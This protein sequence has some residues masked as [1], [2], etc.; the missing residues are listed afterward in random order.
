L[1]AGLGSFD[2]PKYRAGG[3]CLLHIEDDSDV[4]KVIAEVAHKKLSMEMATALEE[5]RKELYAD[6]YDLALLDLT[7]RMGKVM[8]CYRI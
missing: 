6:R 4:T 5:A 1:L 7:C 2:G 8:G 3:G